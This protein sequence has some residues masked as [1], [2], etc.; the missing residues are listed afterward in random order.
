MTLGVLPPDGGDIIGRMFCGRGGTPGAPTPCRRGA[1]AGGTGGLAG[2]D[3]TPGI[4]GVPALDVAPKKK[5]FR[6]RANY[7]TNKREKLSNNSVN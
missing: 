1:G 2:A 4:R 3:G 5:I 7:L 6:I